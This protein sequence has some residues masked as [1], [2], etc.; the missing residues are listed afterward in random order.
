MTGIDNSGGFKTRTVAKTGNYTLTSSDHVVFANAASGGF[1]LT[2]PAA[3]SHS[4][5]EF[6]IIRIDTVGTNNVI[7]G[8]TGGDAVKGWDTYIK[9]GDAIRVISD[10]TLWWWVVSMKGQTER[11]EIPINIFDSDTY[12][13]TGD[14]VVGFVIPTSMDGY[15][16]ED[17][18]AAVHTQG[19]TSGS[20]DVQV[21]RRRSGADTDMLSTKVTISYNAYY[22]SDGVISTSTVNQGDV[23]FVDVDA[24]PSGGTPKGLFVTLTFVQEDL[25]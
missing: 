11:I 20:T 10:G 15:E 6:I 19:G 9:P 7:I 21:R 14:G 16:L 4:G 3:G 5:R 24:I 13:Y 2:L 23:I 8:L 1:T 22:A 18:M 12:I 17:V 25:T